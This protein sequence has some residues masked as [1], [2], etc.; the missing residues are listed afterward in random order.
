MKKIEAEA[1]AF[2]EKHTNQLKAE[3]ETL[4]IHLKAE[5]EMR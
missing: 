5:T 3:I 1:K 4:H 2:L